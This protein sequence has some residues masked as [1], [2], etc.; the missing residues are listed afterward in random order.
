MGIIRLNRRKNDT[1]QQ[2]QTK[3]IIEM[4]ISKVCVCLSYLDCISFER[5]SVYLVC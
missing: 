5:S 3:D 4:D 2:T 1:K